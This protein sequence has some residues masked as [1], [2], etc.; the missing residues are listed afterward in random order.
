MAWESLPPL[1]LT[2]KRAPEAIR[3]RTAAGTV[4]ASPALGRKRS[5]WMTVMGG[6]PGPVWGGVWGLFSRRVTPRPSRR[7]A[8]LGFVLVSVRG[9]AGFQESADV[10]GL[11]VALG[12]AE[13]KAAPC[14]PG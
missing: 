8:A 12:F 6:C 11:G 4:K 7:W 10:H 9:A 1:L 13:A 3:S 14:H 5:I 2:A